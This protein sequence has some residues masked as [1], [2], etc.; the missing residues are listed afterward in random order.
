MREQE[1]NFV[2]LGNIG[3]MYGSCG[4][5]VSAAK[6]VIEWISNEVLTNES[7]DSAELGISSSNGN[8]LGI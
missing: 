2:S 7:I 8:S 1:R 6:L 4:T 5:N 3:G